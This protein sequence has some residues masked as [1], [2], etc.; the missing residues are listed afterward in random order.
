MSVFLHNMVI[1]IY[2]ALIIGKK[3]IRQRTPPVCIGHSGRNPCVPQ[4]LKTM[5]V[6]L[7]CRVQAAAG[8]A[9]LHGCCAA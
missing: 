2:T 6:Y 4:K 5:V 3:L 9:S 1:L 7:R 8:S